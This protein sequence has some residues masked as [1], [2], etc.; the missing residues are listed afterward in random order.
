MGFETFPE[1][2]DESYDTELNMIERQRKI[3]ENVLRW[4]DN[5]LE[6][7]NQVRK[8]KWKLEHNHNHLLNLDVEKLIYDDLYTKA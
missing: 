2:F 8:I 7:M 4:K 1:L 6:F 5:K 3:V